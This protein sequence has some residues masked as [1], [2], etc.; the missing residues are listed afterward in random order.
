MKQNQSHE[1]WRELLALAAAGALDASEERALREHLSTCA[2]CAAEMQAWQ[3]TTG[4]LRGLPAPLPRIEAVQRTQAAAMHALAVAQ[5]KRERR[6]GLAL[7]IAASWLVTTASMGLLQ[8]ACA[9]WWPEAAPGAAVAILL[10]FTWSAVGTILCA[11][12]ARER[13]LGRQA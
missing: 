10:I 5:E 13:F 2:D 9:R 1:S 3:A 12:N 6:N 8:A 7:A 4:A 11:S